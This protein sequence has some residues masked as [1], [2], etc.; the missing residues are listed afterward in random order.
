MNSFELIG[1]PMRGQS[2]VTEVLSVDPRRD[3]VELQ[4]AIGECR[5]LDRVMSHVHGSEP[6]VTQKLGYLL[7]ES[8]A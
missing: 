7:R 3:L 4:Y 5:G 8:L 2:R 1:A 6:A